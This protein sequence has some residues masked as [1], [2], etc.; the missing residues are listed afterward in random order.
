MIVE[1]RTLAFSRDAGVVG[2]NA[3]MGALGPLFERL[4][5]FPHN[6]GSLNEVTISG[7]QTPRL[8]GWHINVVCIADCDVVPVNKVAFCD[9]VDDRSIRAV[10]VLLLLQCLQH[11]HPNIRQVLSDVPDIASSLARSATLLR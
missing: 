9:V 5:T 7:G 1:S 3:L 8:A 6:V 11:R 10:G 4:E 2:N